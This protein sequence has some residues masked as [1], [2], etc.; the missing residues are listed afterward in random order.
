MTSKQTLHAVVASNGACLGR[1]VILSTVV[2]PTKAESVSN[3]RARTLDPA[4]NSKTRR[5]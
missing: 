3:K 5:V 2:R 1:P 4:R